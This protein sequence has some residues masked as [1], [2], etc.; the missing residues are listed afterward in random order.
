MSA[1]G[2]D[3]WQNAITRASRQALKWHIATFYNG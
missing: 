2:V 1:S 3:E